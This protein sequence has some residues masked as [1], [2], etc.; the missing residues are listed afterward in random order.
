[1]IVSGEPAVL[2]SNME[3]VDSPE[4]FVKLTEARAACDL[5]SLNWSRHLN[6]PEDQNAKGMPQRPTKTK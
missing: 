1:M 6:D 2:T 3:N 4:I 5:Y